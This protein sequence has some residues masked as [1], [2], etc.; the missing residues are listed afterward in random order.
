MQNEFSTLSDI[1]NESV[2]DL[3]KGHNAIKHG[4]IFS[5]WEQI[6][7]KKFFK[8]TRP[9]SIKGSKIYVSCE[10]SFVV[11]ELLM[12]KKLLLNKIK[13]YCEPLGIKIDD[14]VFDYKSWSNLKNIPFGDENFP[15][16]YNDEKIEQVEIDLNSLQ[17]TFAQIDKSEFLDDEQKLKFKNQII[18]VQKANKLRNL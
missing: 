7:G 11:Q 5:F 10:N 17:E 13:P 1:L 4:T 9:N 6:V 18:R 3:K 12:H 14:F 2:F 8:T 15:Q 16:F